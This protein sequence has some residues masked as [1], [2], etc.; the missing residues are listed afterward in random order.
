MGI[1]LT[2]IEWK[3]KNEWLDKLLEQPQLMKQEIEQGFEAEVIRFS[4]EQDSFVLKLWNKSSRPNV[5]FQYRLL[6]ALHEQG[7]SVSRPIG[8][9]MNADG[10]R[11]LLTTYDGDPLLKVN[12]EKVKQM[13]SVL[14]GIHRV[15]AR[16]LG[17][18]GLPC[19][20]F[21]NYFF[22]GVGDM[23][24]LSSVL[25]GLLRQF[26]V[27][28]EHLI[29]GDFHL[30]NLVEQK[31]RIT[32]IDW[33]N[34]QLGDARYDLAWALVLLKLYVSKRHAD[35]LRAFYL[36]E[37]PMAP[38]ELEAY[39]A[40]AMLRWILLARRGGAPS[41]PVFLERMNVMLAGNGHLSEMVLSEL[42]PG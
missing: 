41:A 25:S 11:A 39:E 35:W 6:Q 23:T 13:A 38:E 42:L 20:E 37:R 40:I 29:H 7:V 22:P 31:N 4:A 26:P 18:I 14:S 16:E 1:P 36:K 8:W 12:K 34:G 24:K 3:A 33:T 28:Q 17:S 32:V 21:T 2:D 27:K 10:E 19:C 5:E 30:R 15:S 9:G